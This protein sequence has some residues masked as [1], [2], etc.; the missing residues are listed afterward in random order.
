MGTD[1]SFQLLDDASSTSIIFMV[2]MRCD[3]WAGGLLLALVFNHISRGT[4]RCMAV[5]DKMNSLLFR[6][7]SAP[8]GGDDYGK[9][10]STERNCE[11]MFFAK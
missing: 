1:R 10:L 7:L 6:T 4:H 9:Q 11:N 3:P 2:V 8:F 5:E